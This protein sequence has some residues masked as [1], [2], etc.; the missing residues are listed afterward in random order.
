LQIAKNGVT[1]YV[2]KI[3][4]KKENIVAKFCTACSSALMH[5]LWKFYQ[6]MRWWS[7][8]FAKNVMIWHG[9]TLVSPLD[10]ISAIKHIY[11]EA[12]CLNICQKFCDLLQA[13]NFLNKMR[14]IY[15][16][17][18]TTLRTTDPCVR[19]KDE[20]LICWLVRVNAD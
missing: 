14:F 9:M 5:I 16:P 4:P 15:G 18:T 8:K 20:M 10:N 13:N 7:W 17:Q 19:G 6:N 2:F 12:P 1:P 3:P 11:S